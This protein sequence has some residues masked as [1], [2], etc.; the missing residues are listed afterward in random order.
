MHLPRPKL[1]NDR[2]FRHISDVNNAEVQ[3]LTRSRGA[4]VIP[5]TS[6]VVLQTDIQRV[7]GC[8]S[9]VPVALFPTSCMHVSPFIS[10]GFYRV[11]HDFCS[12]R[13]RGKSCI[14]GF[15]EIMCPTKSVSAKLAVPTYSTK[16]GPSLVPSRMFTRF[17][18]PSFILLVEARWN[19]LEG[20]SKTV[21]VTHAD[22]QHILWDQQFDWCCLAT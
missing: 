2:V 6:L 15:G 22:Y 8:R 1:F 17:T 3:N 4:K 18:M 20:H 13:S 7:P 16:V 9:V 10:C 21:E 11:I 19:E 12:L 14:S 5:Y